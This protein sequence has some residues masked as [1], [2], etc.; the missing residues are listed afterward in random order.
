MAHFVLEYVVVDD[1]VRRR[2]EYRT[3]H[4]ALARQAHERGDLVLAGALADPVDRAVLVW[5]VEDPSV[6][7]RF[8]EQDP[9]VRH[10]LV[11][12]W[13]IRPWTVVVGGEGGAM[14]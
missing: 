4:L 9:Y 13:S 5:S 11:R 12:S 7:E 1:Y 2:A 10:G 3:E 6:V 8:V 14:A